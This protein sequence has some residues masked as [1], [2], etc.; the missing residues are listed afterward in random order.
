VKNV[1]LDRTTILQFD[2][3]CTDGALD[4]TTDCKVLR[5]DA[6]LDLCTIAD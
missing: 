2:A 5:N 4:V 6:A 3:D 1:T